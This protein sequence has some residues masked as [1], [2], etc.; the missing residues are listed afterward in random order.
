V[1]E[2]TDEI[3]PWQGADVSESEDTEEGTKKRKRK[4]EELPFSTV[5]EIN[6]GFI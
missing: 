6:R 4:D 5:E 1:I 2:E 3:E